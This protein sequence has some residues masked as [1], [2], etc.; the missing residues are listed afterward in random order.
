MRRPCSPRA[1]YAGP[2]INQEVESPDLTVEFTNEER[3][4][5]AGISAE[6]TPEERQRATEI[7]AT[8]AELGRRQDKLAARLVT[9][10][11]KNKRVKPIERELR[12]IGVQTESLLAEAT[13]ILAEGIERA[14]THEEAVTV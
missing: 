3:D 13:A 14:R 8:L 9:V 5:A 1:V 6:F 11:G 12:A 10:R 4:R 2:S 7:Y